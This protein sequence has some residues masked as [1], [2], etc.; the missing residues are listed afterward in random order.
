[1]IQSRPWGGWEL[2]HKSDTY[3]VKRI[4]VNPQSR[5]S[6][7]YHNHRKEHWYCV[8][9]RGIVTI[10]N[11][12]SEGISS[13]DS[14]TI[15]LGSKHR[16][17]NISPSEYLIIVEVQEGVYLEEDDIVRIEDDYDRD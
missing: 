10:D 6:L 7:Q 4:V 5:L 15:P 3:A 12:E 14:V 9:G 16:L 1:M 13:G 2:L 17:E 11:Y 8:A